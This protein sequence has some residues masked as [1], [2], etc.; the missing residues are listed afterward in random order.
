ML[1]RRELAFL[2]VI[3]GLPSA[4][5]LLADGG[6]N[7]LFEGIGQRYLDGLAPYDVDRDI[8]VRRHLNRFAALPTAARAVARIGR[9]ALTP[10]AGHYMR[11]HWGTPQIRLHSAM[12]SFLAA[13]ALTAS[14]GCRQHPGQA[15][16]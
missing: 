8:R 16:L 3:R 9:V 13:D 5:H 12:A 14:I 7:R 6:E 11:V 2:V 4:K 15:G 10:G 1:R